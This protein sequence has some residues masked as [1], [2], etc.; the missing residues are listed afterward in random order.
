MLCDPGTR[1][2]RYTYIAFSLSLSLSLSSLLTA[3]KRPMRHENANGTKKEAYFLHDERRKGNR[4]FYDDTGN[5][6][7]LEFPES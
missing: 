2:D 1:V 7:R 5:K 3:A 6:E 4:N